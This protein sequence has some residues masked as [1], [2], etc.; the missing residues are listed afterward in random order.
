MSNN[1]NNDSYGGM[2]SRSNSNNKKEM[3]T[4]VITTMKS[5]GN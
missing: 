5:A 3:M 1:I 2:P 4:T